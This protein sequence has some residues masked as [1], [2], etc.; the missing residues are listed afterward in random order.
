MVKF[1]AGLVLGTLLGMF[2]VHSFP[3]ALSEWFA[4]LP[5]GGLL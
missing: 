3:T 1:I 5:L 2:L 4:W